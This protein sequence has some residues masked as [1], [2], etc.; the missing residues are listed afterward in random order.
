LRMFLEGL[1]RAFESKAQ[2]P[3]VPIKLGGS[4]MEERS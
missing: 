3:M 1:E 2:I 4:A